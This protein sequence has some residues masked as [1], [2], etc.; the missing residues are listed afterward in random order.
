MK[1]QA[2]PSFY[3]YQLPNWMYANWATNW[4]HCIFLLLIQTIIIAKASSQLYW[5]IRIIYIS[6][7][8]FIRDIKSLKKVA[9]LQ[10]CYCFHPYSFLFNQSS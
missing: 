3:G 4:A 1:N 2:K 5:V 9:L 8:E 7:F 10:I 6:S